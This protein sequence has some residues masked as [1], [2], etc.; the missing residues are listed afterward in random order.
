MGNIRELQDVIKRAVILSEGEI[1][2]I[3]ESWAK[4]ESFRTSVTAAVESKNAFG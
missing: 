4:R 3:E 1:F 2:S